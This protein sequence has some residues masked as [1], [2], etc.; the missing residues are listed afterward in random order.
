MIEHLRQLAERADGD[1]ADRRLADVDDD[2][3][4]HPATVSRSALDVTLS[5]RGSPSTTLTRPPAASTRPAQSVASAPVVWARRNASAA[6]ACGVCTAQRPSR[7][8]V[9]CTPPPG[10][11]RFSV[12]PTG[13]PG[14]APSQPSESGASTRSTTS[15][16]TSGRAAS[17][18]RTTSASAGT[19]PRPARTESLLVSPPV[20]QACTLPQPSSSATRIAGSSQPGGATRTIRSTQGQASRRR[21][22]SARSGSSPSFANA[23]GRS[24]PSRSPRPAATRMAQ[25]DMCERRGPL[26]RRGRSGL[27]LR[28]LLLRRAVRG[29][30]VLEPL[31]AGLLVHVLRVH[32]LGGE[33]LLRLHEHLLLAGRETLLPVAKSEVPDD[34]GELE[35]VA[36]LH[37]VAAVLVAAIPVLR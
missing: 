24:S 26:G 23:F 35:D 7:E 31:G 9:S 17:C 11:T 1:G 14:T 21:S 32:Q 25:T 20:T 37:L 6:K 16:V 28:R 30:D 5:R 19:S 10:P 15:S 33:D 12:S 18:T 34:L 13:S 36:G 2:A 4:R 29:Q 3:Q 22:G 8:T 27:L